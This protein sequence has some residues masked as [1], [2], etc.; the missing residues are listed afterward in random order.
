MLSA[1]SVVVSSSAVVV[2]LPMVS[3]THV[4]SHVSLLRNWLDGFV[5]RQLI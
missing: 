4:V 3:L 5:E 1:D 2:A